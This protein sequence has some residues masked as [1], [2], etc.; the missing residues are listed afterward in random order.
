[1]KDPCKIGD[2]IRLIE[3]PDDPNPISPGS[4]GVVAGMRRWHAL[5]TEIQIAVK[6]DSGR[7]L[8]MIHPID[9]FEVIST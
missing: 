1:M 7:T 5:S 2:R 8:A 6:W 4:E 3:M 9:K